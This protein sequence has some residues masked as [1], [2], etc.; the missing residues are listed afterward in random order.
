MARS[1]RG[2]FGHFRYFLHFFCSTQIAIQVFSIGVRMSSAF[3]PTAIEPSTPHI[4]TRNL[5][6]AFGCIAFEWRGGFRFL[7]ISYVFSLCVWNFSVVLNLAI[8][9]ICVI[10]TLFHLLHLVLVCVHDVVSV[11]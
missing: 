11:L 1:E 7:F 9:R 4:F 8:A 3:S 2:T 5:P 6:I 10:F